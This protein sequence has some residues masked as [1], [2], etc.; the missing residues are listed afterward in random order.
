MGEPETTAHG[1]AGIIGEL[2]E[3]YE[4]EYGDKLIA[5]DDGSLIGHKFKFDG[6]ELSVNSDI[7]NIL[8]AIVSNGDTLLL[9][10]DYGGNQAEVYQ[11]SF[12]TNWD[13]SSLSYDNKSFDFGGF[14][15]EPDGIDT[16]GD[17]L[18]VL[19]SDNERIYQWNFGSSWDVSTLSGPDGNFNDLDQQDTSPKGITT[20]GSTLIMSG[21]NTDSL[22]QYSFGTDWDIKTVSY[23]NTSYDVSGETT[24]ANEIYSDGEYLLLIDRGSNDIQ[25]YSFGTEWDISTL[26]HYVAINAE[27][28]TGTTKRGVTSGG[29]VGILS[30]AN[31][32]LYSYSFEPEIRIPER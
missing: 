10:D 25:Q 18:L 5:E 30:D 22:Y 7:S 1:L 32:V 15:N 29:G 4:E 3:E 21:N 14:I 27:S 6:R 12:G 23:D 17:T 8:S 2:N 11:Y 13:L 24:N 9:L 20:D 28:E 31:G 26:S 16:D 19:G